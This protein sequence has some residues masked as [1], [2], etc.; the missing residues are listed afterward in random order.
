MQTTPDFTVVLRG[1]DRRQV[2][3]L[4]QQAWDAI[5][6]SDAQLRET[7]RRALAEPALRVRLRGYD[8]EQV[9][10]YLRQVA[11]ELAS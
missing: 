11:Q 4:L 9:H 1:Y 10:L 5:G 3:A 8:R 2:D 7:T 6:S